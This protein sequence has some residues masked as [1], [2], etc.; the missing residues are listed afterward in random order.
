MSEEGLLGK[1]LQDILNFPDFVKQR[2]DVIANIHGVLDY[3]FEKKGTLSPVDF[4]KLNV[5]Y[6]V[7]LGVLAEAVGFL[8]KNK[9]LD[10]NSKFIISI[11][12]NFQIIMP[13]VHF[14]IIKFSKCYIY[15]KFN[16]EIIGQQKN[17][18]FRK[19][20]LYYGTSVSF[21]YHVFIVFAIYVYFLNE[22]FIRIE[23][24]SMAALA[25]GF[26]FWGAANFVSLEAVAKICNQVRIRYNVILAVSFLIF[27]VLFQYFPIYILYIGVQAL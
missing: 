25:V 22:E 8:L 18:D 12:A 13:I 26:Y 24:I 4:A 16:S 6:V 21:W 19:L 15:G 7:L 1:K 23:L 14:A 11:L 17:N 20:Y 27:Y 9:N 2:R 5:T 3:D 10:T